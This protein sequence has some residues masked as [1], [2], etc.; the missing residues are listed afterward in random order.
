MTDR[1]G[2]QYGDYRLVSLMGQS[3]FAD[4]YLGEHISLKAQAA[5]K[6][7]QVHITDNDRERF[8]ND[9]STIASLVHPHIVQLLDFGVEDEMPFLIM[10]YAPNG[11]LRQR[12][13]KGT[14]LPITSIISYVMQV[15][16][17]LQYA[18]EREVIHHNVKPGNMLLGS[19]GDVL[20]GDFAIASF[21]QSV[22][23]NGPKQSAGS[24]AYMSPEQIKGNPSVKSDQYALGAVVYEWLSGERP[25]HGTPTEIATQQLFASPTPLRQK[26]PSIPFAI[27]EVVMIALAKD[28]H[29]RFR[30]LST[31]ANALE[32]ASKEDASLF[33]VPAVVSPPPA[34]SSLSP[35]ITAQPDVKT[36]ASTS[37]AAPTAGQSLHTR[38]LSRRAMLA[39]LGLAGLSIACVGINAL[40]SQ[41]T[42]LSYDGHS[43]PVHALM[44]SP[45][46]ITRIASGGDDATVQVWDAATGNRFFMGVGHSAPVNAVSW[47]PYS[48]YLVSGSS[49]YTVQVWDTVNGNRSIVYRGHTDAVRSVAWSFDD[50]WIAS[51]GDD[52]TV[53]VWDAYSGSAPFTY[54]GH[55]GVVYSV[56]WSP[57]SKFIASGSGDHTVQVW[58]AQTGER[59]LTYTGHSGPIYA[60]TWSPDGKFIA[61]GSD[62]HTVQVWGAQ[63][64]ERILTYT[65]HSGPV[66]AL[67]WSPDGKFI[68]SGSDDHT[69]QVWGA[70]TG[71]RILTYTGHSGPVHAVTWALDGQ[72]IGSSGDDKTVQVWRVNY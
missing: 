40:L 29:Q 46:D 72:R 9:A 31:F 8:F 3:R 38:H 57:D 12:H 55:A 2:Q 43:G 42:L 35:S 18:H 41:T 27:E 13:P 15:A 24:V 30:D 63:T 19:K 47:S 56:V 4:V 34:I 49:D 39:G 60:L 54:R 17:A 52:T 32:Q 10:E 36:S 23:Q 61:S 20:L 21:M 48:Q 70:Q 5:I 26:N 33:A 51:G 69:V 28:P 11:T 71:E 16:A 64:G 58:D 7:L 66:Y 37:T 25:F 22:P 1:V 53:Q 65:G 6:V 68:A 62:D 44:W 59:I 67:T 50:H 14:V 45:P